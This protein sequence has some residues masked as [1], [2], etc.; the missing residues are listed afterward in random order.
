MK[1]VFVRKSSGPNNN[2]DFPDSNLDLI[3]SLKPTFVFLVL[4]LFSDEIDCN[5]AFVESFHPTKEGTRT[6]F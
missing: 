4:P 6:L 2:V 5:P 1:A 3:V